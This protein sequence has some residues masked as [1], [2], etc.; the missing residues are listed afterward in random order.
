M[1]EFIVDVTLYGN[2]CDLCEE[3]F[4]LVDAPM[5]HFTEH[6]QIKMWVRG[7][8]VDGES[9]AFMVVENKE[10][11]SLTDISEDQETIEQLI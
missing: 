9:S 3:N 10:M 1:D 4:P 5:R 6:D 2:Y 11:E 8:N 7:R